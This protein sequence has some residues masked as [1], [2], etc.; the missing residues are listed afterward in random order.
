MQDDSRLRSIE[1]RYRARH[2][3]L[4]FMRA[5]WWNPQPL[6]VGRHTRAIC[7]RLTRAIE[8]WRRGISTFLLIAVPF[9]HGKSDM[10]SIALPSYFLGRC[11]DAQP[12]VIMATYG[13]SLT[14]RF[15]RQVQR[16]MRSDAYRYVF[17][18]VEPEGSIDSW[19][20]KGSVGTVTAVGLGGAIT[21]KGGHLIVLDDY[22]KSRGEA[23]SR[24][25]RDHTWDA[26]RNDLLS[27][28]NAP[29]SIV[30]VCATPW[31]V[32]D[33]RGRIL[34]EMAETPDFPRFEELN[35]PARK[36]G[37]DGWETLFPERFS[38]EWYASQRAALQ[39]QAAALLDCNPM[40]EGGGRFDPFKGVVVHDTLVGW[41]VLREARGWDL[42]SSAKER[43]GDDPD[44][45]W[46][47]RGG[48][49]TVP[50]SPGVHRTEVWIRSAVAIRAEAPERDA[51]IRR[52]A[53]E[54]GPG[55]IQ[56]IEAFGG[57]KDA[58]TTLRSLLSGVSPVIRSHMPGD[59]SAKLAPLET[60]FQAGAVHV[61]RP[62]FGA[63]FDEWRAEFAAFPNGAHDDGCDATAIMYDV[64]A[65]T[66]VG[67]V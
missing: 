45:T 8:D 38:E 63:W 35:F 28:R 52:T 58:Y 4:D 39:A 65:N 26:F 32:D 18:G 31:H 62:G 51:L 22:C 47:V 15:S 60:P 6:V 12:D 11:A 61:Y 41:P 50:L 5:V 25:F 57:Y 24:T 3:M 59:K 49:R 23:V 44:R 27:R 17:P 67:F 33:V 64:S 14:E 66:P 9:R 7:D 46:G 20:V 21:G 36:P 19:N 42:A 56:A 53:V 43:D 48:V 40:V 1:A 55:V 34:R 16:V 13:A 2:G 54:D 30:I 29:A 10:A 37:P